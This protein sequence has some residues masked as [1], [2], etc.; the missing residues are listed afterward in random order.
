MKLKISIT[1]EL[2]QY[3]ILWIVLG[4]LIFISKFDI[5]LFSCVFY[6]PS[7]RQLIDARS[8]AAGNQ[9]FDGLIVTYDITF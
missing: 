1:T 4:N 3:L 9:Y 2:I 5:R 8:A 6:T 7:N